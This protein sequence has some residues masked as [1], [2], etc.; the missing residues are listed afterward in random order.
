MAAK[1]TRKQIA[2]V[3]VAKQKTGLSETAYR[4]LLAGFG[5]K[6]SKELAR[7]DLPKLLAAFEKFGFQQKKPTKK[8][9]SPHTPITAAQK[10]KILTLWATVSRLPRNEQTMGL[11]TFC[12]RITKVAH[13]DW[14]SVG[15]A[16]KV[17]IALEKM[18]NG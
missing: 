16:Q 13:I 15:L 10:A 18:N 11:N 9:G 2:L 14:L 7:V 6:S 5:V 12:K 3:H 1:I 8:T 17:I 4:D